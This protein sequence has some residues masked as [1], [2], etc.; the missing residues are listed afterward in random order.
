MNEN[1]GRATLI[2]SAIVYPKLQNGNGH[3]L[4]LFM[5]IIIFSLRKGVWRLSG[6][7]EK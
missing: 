6:Y 5:F 7:I 1:I 3:L 2:F 4:D